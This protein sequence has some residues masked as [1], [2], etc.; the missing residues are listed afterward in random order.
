MRRSSFLTA[1]PSGMPPKE[2]QL[3]EGVAKQRRRSDEDIAA[4]TAAASAAVATAL[5]AAESRSESKLLDED[6]AK[7]EAENAAREAKLNLESRPSFKEV[8]KTPVKEM[9]SDTKLRS[10]VSGLRAIPHHHLLNRR[11]HRRMRLQRSH[12]R[13]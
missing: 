6:I 8:M 7:L 10:Q 9:M 5:K 12:Q 11:G 1:L 4:A 3:D 2:P 13:R